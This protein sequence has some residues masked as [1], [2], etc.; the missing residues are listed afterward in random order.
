[1]MNQGNRTCPFTMGQ[2]RFNGLWLNPFI[3]INSHTNDSLLCLPLLCETCGCPRQ[4]HHSCWAASAY[5]TH[6]Y[7]MYT[8]CVQSKT[9]PW[10]HTANSHVLII[11]FSVITMWSWQ[12]L[13]ALLFVHIQLIWPC[14]FRLKLP[15]SVKLTL[16]G[17]HSCKHGYSVD[18]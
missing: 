1:M 12:V 16:L 15:L 3:S 7:R 11:D 18:F 4:V 8:E 6:I 2:G 13:A 14:S 9:L 10:P 5:Q 17:V